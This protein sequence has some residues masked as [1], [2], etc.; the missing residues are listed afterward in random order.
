[1][2]T[3]QLKID[4]AY[5]KKYDGTLISKEEV[6][7]LNESLKNSNG[8][9]LD[10]CDSVKYTQL[11]GLSKFFGMNLSLYTLRMPLSTLRDGK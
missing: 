4:E 11:E 3:D 9:Y 7:L 8:S 2:K 1:M 10:F 6:E 5:V